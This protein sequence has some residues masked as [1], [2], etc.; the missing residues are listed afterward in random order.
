MLNPEDRSAIEG[1]F[2]RLREVEQRTEPRDP[3]AEALI[4]ELI[5]RQPG[6]PYSMAQTI[7][8]Q[9]QALRAAEQRIKELEAQL[10]RRPGDVFGGL[11]GSGR[12]A[13]RPQPQRDERGPWERQDRYGGGGFLA[14]AAQTALGV[15]GG[16][17][18]GSAIGSLLGAGAANAAEPPPE[19]EP[20]QGADTGDAGNEG[21]GDF[22]DGGGFDFGGDF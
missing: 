21:G 17:L 4:R 12:S 16:L 6:A 20:D 9:E 18:L 1:L 14:G 22:G 2:A 7:L 8:V 10:E 13:R 5:S 15:T 11:F 19:P 3:E